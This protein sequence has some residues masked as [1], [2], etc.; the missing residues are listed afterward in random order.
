MWSHGLF[1]NHTAATFFIDKHPWPYKSLLEYR[2]TSLISTAATNVA[3]LTFMK[4][5]SPLPPVKARGTVEFAAGG[6]AVVST[7]MDRV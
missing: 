5:R 4:T 2:N 3:V 7:L 1:I 6:N